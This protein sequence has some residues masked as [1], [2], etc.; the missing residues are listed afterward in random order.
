MRTVTKTVYKFD[1]LSPE[2]QEKAIEAN[3]RIEVDYCNWWDFEFEAIDR[4]AELLGIEIERQKEKGVATKELCIYFSGFYHQGSGL[5]FDAFYRHAKGCKKAISKEFPRDE[6]LQQIATALV[7]AQKPLRY[8]GQARVT[9]SNRGH[10]LCF[11]SDSEY[12]DAAISDFAS[13]AYDSLKTQFEYL[14]SREVVI[15]SLKANECEFNEDGT[16]A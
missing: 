13:W 15:D 10:Y 2:A 4:A 9:G 1:E 6:K 7:K 12:I 5:S 14:T 3:Y 11:D 16:P 8:E